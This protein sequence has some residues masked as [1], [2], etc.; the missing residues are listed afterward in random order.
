MLI[1]KV[2]EEI[3]FRNLSEIYWNLIM[4]NNFWE[5]CYQLSIALVAQVPSDKVIATFRES[6]KRFDLNY[7]EAFC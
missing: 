7:V 4:K 3:I 1:V 2:V 6:F 5:V